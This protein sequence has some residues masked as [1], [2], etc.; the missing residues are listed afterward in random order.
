MSPARE[1]EVVRVTTARHSHS[2]D[3]RLRQR[4]YMWMQAL[5]IACVVLGALLPVALWIKAAI[6]VGAVVLPWLGVVMANAGPTVASRKDRQN[7]IQAGLSDTATPP[8]V[9]IDPTRVVDG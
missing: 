2:D 4:R 1:P 9:P 3:I 7:A 5:R 6:W 8:P